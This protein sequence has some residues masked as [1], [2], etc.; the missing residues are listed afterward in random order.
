MFSVVTLAPSSENKESYVCQYFSAVKWNSVSFFVRIDLSRSKKNWVWR[1]LR[2]LL[3]LFPCVA[4][5]GG[6]TSERIS[7]I[8]D[9]LVWTGAAVLYSKCEK[10]E[11]T[12]RNTTNQWIN[13]WSLFCRQQSYRFSFMKALCKVILSPSRSN[14]FS[15]S[16]ALTV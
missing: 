5:A 6:M 2:R 9:P 15:T 12:V 16:L 11:K 1:E 8:I 10:N 3:R 14:N 4:I 13:W 7:L